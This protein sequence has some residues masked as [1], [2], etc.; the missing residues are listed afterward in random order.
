M[1]LRDLVNNI[2]FKQ[3]LKPQARTAAANGTGVDTRGYGA[4]AF[5]VDKGVITDGTHV[6]TVE[7]SDDDSTY[8]AIAAAD[9]DGSFTP[10]TSAV[11]AT[12]QKVGYKGN[13][14]YVRAV[15][16]PSGTTT[17]GVYSVGVL[18]GHAEQRPVV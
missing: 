8:T 6:L 15:T 13:M 17:G 9:L 4:V 7:E 10:L 12:T 3:S 11:T 1:I 14:R 5:L 16:T 18:L 2:L